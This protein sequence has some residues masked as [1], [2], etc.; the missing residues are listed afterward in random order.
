[1][2]LSARAWSAQ[3][4][5]G[6]PGPHPRISA[7]PALRP[8]LQ[9][10]SCLWPGGNLEGARLLKGAHQA[11]SATAPSEPILFESPLGH[12]RLGTHAEQPARMPMGSTRQ[13]ASTATR[14]GCDADYL[15]RSSQ[16]HRQLAWHAFVTKKSRRLHC[17]CRSPQ[18]YRTGRWAWAGGPPRCASPATT[19]AMYQPFRHIVPNT[20]WQ[21]YNYAKEAR[22][23]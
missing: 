10:G 1:M 14:S 22:L 9:A 20:K 19:V 12:G 4:S 3:G 13:A 8:P 5:C 17:C 2:G 16:G 11:R 15:P 7:G 18:Q 21:R 6:Y 23:M